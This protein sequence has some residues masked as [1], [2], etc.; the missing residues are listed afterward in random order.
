[1]LSWTDPAQNLYGPTDNSFTAT[2]QAPI[3]TISLTA[4][5]EITSGETITYAATLNNIG[6]AAASQVS[7]TITLPNGTQQV[8]N[9]GGSSIPVG[10]SL[11]A[12]ATYPVPL[13]QASGPVSAT[14]A[15]TWHDAVMN[16]YGPLSSSATTNVK[17]ANQPPVV[18]A[19]PNQ[20]VPF[21]NVYPLQGHVTDDGLPNATLISTWTQISG[22]SQATFS[23]PHSPTSTVALTAIGTYVFR[24]TGDDSQLTASADVAITTTSANLPP[25]V[26]VGPD[27]TITLP[28]NTVSLTGSATDDG[29]PAGSVLAFTW[30]KIAGPGTVTFATPPRRTR[31][32]HSAK[33]ARISC[34]SPF[35]IPS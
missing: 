17:Q 8:L 30:N 33:A 21:P 9:F 5:A 20:T 29:L 3:V 34:A 15:V 25:A 12:T 7:A 14:A 23:D 28:V 1:M 13:R 19:G 35:P 27:Q 31:P 11:T 6:L 16:N 10:G 18:D 26:R 2:E 32:P 22:P 24:L 4:P